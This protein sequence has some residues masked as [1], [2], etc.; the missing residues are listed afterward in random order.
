MS[1]PRFAEPVTVV[2]VHRNRVEQVGLTV[3]AFRSQTVPTQVMVV[4]NGSEAGAV[5][6]L[7]ST[8]GDAELIVTGENLGFGPGANIGMRR[9]LQGGVGEWV[10]LAPHDAMP[11]PDAIEKMLSAVHDMPLV[12]LMSADVGDNAL[13]IIQPFLG[14]IDAEPTVSEGFDRSDYPHGTLMMCRRRFLSEVGLF[15]ER[16]FAYCEE[17]ELGIRAARAG[18]LCG[19]IRGAE[20]RNPGMSSSVERVAYLQ[21]RNTLLMLREHYGVRNSLFRILV[22]LVQIPVGLVYEPAR[23]LHWSV[24]GRLLAIR[25]HLR[26]RYGPP[27]PQVNATEHP[28]GRTRAA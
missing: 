13:P 24:R 2:V 1:D 8:V 14:S 12:G 28:H 9:F 25:D 10:A 3:E 7:P 6:A 4:D 27:P 22:A 5:A 19:V 20:V 16:Y 26:G 17:A 18:W 21:L 15:D 23:G 11:E